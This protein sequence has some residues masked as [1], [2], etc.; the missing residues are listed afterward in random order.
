MKEFS[1]PARISGIKPFLVM[2]IMER[3]HQLEAQGRDVIHLEVGEP[4]FDT[5]GVITRAAES[6]LCAGHTHY[7][8]ALGIPELR[9]VIAE[10]YNHKYGVSVSPGRVVVTNGTSPGLLMLFSVLVDA[11]DE[12]VISDPHYA[13]YPAFILSA[14]GRPVRVPTHAEHGFALKAEAV[15]EHIT[16]N[17]RAILINSPSNPTGASLSRGDMAALAELGV[18]IVSDEIYHGLSYEDAEY[19]ALHFTED[20]FVINGFSKY[21]AMT[22][23]RVGYLIVPP[24]YVRP[25]EILQQNYFVSPNSF[26][27]HA[28]VAALKDGVPE[29][30][31][32]RGIY[33]E[34]RKIMLA[35][36]EDIGLKMLHEPTGAFYAF[37]DARAYGADSLE[38]A[39]EILE[40][41]G[42]AVAPGADFGPGGEGFLRFSYCNSVENIEAGL[43]RVGAFLRERQERE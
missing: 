24:E 6:A 31:R 34:R 42:V 3:A 17:T 22:G 8:A 29:A 28:A 26:V 21:F 39:K 14:C 2:D 5:P 13:C 11:G 4:D 33:N 7:T 35:R 18:P 15:R 43:E 37:A 16:E 9:E 32:M 30:E 38:L 23:W 12:I 40:A 36:L 27:Q 41:T 25:L 10:Y 19:T 20:C 1:I